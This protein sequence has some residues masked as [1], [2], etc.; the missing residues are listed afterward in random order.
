MTAA[1]ADP[2]PPGLPLVP[3]Q[4][5]PRCVTAFRGIGI[6]TWRETLSSAAA[7]EA[8][9]STPSMLIKSLDTVLPLQPQVCAATGG[10]IDDDPSAP[11]RTPPEVV[12]RTNSAR[13]ECIGR[14]P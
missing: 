2:A 1:T 14:T 7:S 13:I 6:P 4:L 12:R 8:R 11:N 3:R 9:V 10:R 5:P